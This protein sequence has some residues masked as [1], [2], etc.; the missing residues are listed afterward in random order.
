MV[1]G[2]GGVGKTTLA[3]NTAVKFAQNGYKVGLIDLDPQCNLSELVLGNVYEKN[4][5]SGSQKTTYD[6]VR[7]L[8]S[9]TGDVDKSIQLMNTSHEN[10]YLL[11]GSLQLSL[12][13]ELLVTNFS[14]AMSGNEAGYTITSAISR[15]LLDKGLYQEFDLFIIDTSPSLGVLNKIILLDA[16]YFVTPMKPDN[17][18]LMGV[19]NLGMILEKWKRQWQVGALALAQDVPSQKVIG[20]ESL[21]LGYVVNDYNQYNEKPISAHE[22][23]MGKLA[24]PIKEYLSEKHGKNGLVERSWKEELAVIKDYGQLPARSQELNKAIFE[25]NPSDF[26]QGTKENIQKSNDEFNRLFENIAH[27][28]Y[29]LLHR[30]APLHKQ[31][32]RERPLKPRQCKI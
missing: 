23:W 7:K 15:Y 13:E 4:L 9:A 31:L 8:V 27:Q 19:E 2:L 16:D 32:Y 14:S 28:K 3:Y 30:C 12:F 25:F 17:F 10:L 5:F 29:H 22:E 1:Y 21:F 6:V 11:P 24:Q 26:P 20:A 18:S